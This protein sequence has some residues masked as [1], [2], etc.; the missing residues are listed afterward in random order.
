MSHCITTPTGKHVDLHTTKGSYEYLSEYLLKT[1]ADSI[2]F[3]A[4][5]KLRP[6]KCP[7]P[8]PAEEV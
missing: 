8:H 1:G 3:Y 5:E 7:A 6:K 4:L 2:T